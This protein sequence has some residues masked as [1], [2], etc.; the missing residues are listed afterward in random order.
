MVNSNNHMEKSTREF[1]KSFAKIVMESSTEKGIFYFIGTGLKGS[2]EALTVEGLIAIIQSDIIYYD[3]YTSYQSEDL[4]NDLK[5]I[6]KKEI[7]SINRKEVEEQYESF[8]KDLQEKSISFLVTG[9]P[10]VATTHHWLYDW[11]ISK[12]VNVK[13]INNVSIIH[14]ISSILGLHSYK[15]GKTTSI[16]Y[17]NEEYVPE[18][19]VKTIQN[20]LSINAHTIVLLDLDK[21][22]FMDPRIAMKKLLNT[23]IK[24]GFNMEESK[25]VFIMRAG[26][27]NEKILF[28]TAKK[29]TEIKECLLP[30]SIVIL[31]KD[32]HYTEEESLNKWVL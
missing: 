18:S 15:F 26:M 17:Y 1:V 7:I 32:L 25:A 10:F 9:D 5:Y 23:T 21:G 6:T 13:V 20:N 29:L 12:N 24:I 30:A 11:L 19:V 8:Y 3:A 27:E 2:L 22:Y 16:P 28:S 31:A 14:Y 4:V